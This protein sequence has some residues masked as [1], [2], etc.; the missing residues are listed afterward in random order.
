MLNASAEV[1][2]VSLN[3]HGMLPLLG[4]SLRAFAVVKAINLA[5]GLVLGLAVFACGW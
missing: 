3:V 1:T 2:T 5:I 4:D